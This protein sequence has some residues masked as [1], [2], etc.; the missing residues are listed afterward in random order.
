MQ[1]SLQQAR[2][3]HPLAQQVCVHA[4]M[5]ELCAQ[6][7]LHATLACM[8]A[9]VHAHLCTHLLSVNFALYS[10]SSP[11]TQTLVSAEQT[12]HFG[13]VMHFRGLPRHLGSPGDQVHLHK[14]PKPKSRLQTVR[15]PCLLV[16]PKRG[17]LNAPRIHGSKQGCLQRCAQVSP[18]TSFAR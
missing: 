13:G 3:P 6:G 10:F 1:H 17:K 7:R 18:W 12:T 16:K 15:R 2:L 5:H 14:A 8:C 9:C 4:C 11:Q